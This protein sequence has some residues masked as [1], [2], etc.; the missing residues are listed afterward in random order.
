MKTSHKWAW[1]ASILLATLIVLVY[2]AWPYRGFIPIA[3][4]PPENIA[5]LIRQSESVSTS[6]SEEG[7]VKSADFPLQM[8]DGVSIGVF[9]EGLDAPRVLGFDPAGRLLASIPSQGRIVMLQDENQDGKAEVSDVVTGLN[10]PHGFDFYCEDESCR[11]FVGESNALSVFAYH[12]DTGNADGR[13]LLASLPDNGRHWTKSVALIN[14]ESEERVLVSIG[15][16]CDACKESDARRAS[17]QSFRLDG[18]DR[19]AYAVGLRNA[20][21]LTKHPETGAVWATEMGRDYEGDDLPPDEIDLLQKGG[22]YGWPFCFGDRVQDTKFDAGAGAAEYCKNTV[23]PKVNLQ[24]HSAPLGLGFVP[25]NA[26]WPETYEG[27]LFVAY[28]GSWNRTV[29][30]GYKVVR[31]AFDEEGSPLPVEDFI[32]GWLSSKGVFGRPSGVAIAPNGFLYVADDRAGLIYRV[33]VSK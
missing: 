33:H 26:G 29:P 14:E 16:S 17:V 5:D 21:F 32:T 10:R 30:T 28:H 13:K 1:A 20:V 24:A 31:I 15:S 7:P 11:I 2:F 9:A 25:Q 8:P 23:L 4:K 6:T 3:Q 22:I 12:V 19:K 18:T 27:S